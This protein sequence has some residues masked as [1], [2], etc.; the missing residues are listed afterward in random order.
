MWDPPRSDPAQIS[1]CALPHP[2]PQVQVGL[3]RVGRPPPPDD[4][5]CRVKP[6]LKSPPRGSAN[7]LPH[8]CAARGAADGLPH[9]LA[10]PPCRIA[11]LLCLSCPPTEGGGG[12]CAVSGG[13]GGHPVPDPG[14]VPDTPEHLS[15]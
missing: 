5:T 13:E 12:G 2:R 8:P 10:C 4:C 15:T 11:A 9:A 6:R 7:G 3:W 1:G 14:P